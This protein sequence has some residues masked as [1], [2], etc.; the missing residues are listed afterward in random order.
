MTATNIERGSQLR[1][2]QLAAIHVC[3][4]QLAMDEASYR[5][6]L[7]RVSATCGRAVT[8]SAD[9]NGHQRAA[10]IEEMRRLGAG[11]PAGQ[12]KARS[13]PGKPHNIGTMPEMIAKIEAQL[14]DMKLPWAYADAIAKQQCGVAKVAW[15]RQPEPLRAILAALHVEQEKR[16]LD[17]QVTT[18]L[19]ELGMEPTELVTLLR[20]LR[21]NWRRH[22]PSLKL[23]CNYLF[24][25]RD[26]RA[27][28]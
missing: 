20:P 17:A 28:A 7:A 13:Y 18:L 22:R 10:V 12:N 24:A 26:E 5:A 14:A 9:L 23:V 2:K 6:M 11:R 3:R 8:S 25:L 16:H 21:P 15:V 27:E 4:Q 1:R 19:T